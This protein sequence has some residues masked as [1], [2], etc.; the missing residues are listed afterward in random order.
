MLI[1]S[2][3]FN[4]IEGNCRRATPL[5]LALCSDMTRTMCKISKL[6]QCWCNQMCWGKVSTTSCTSRSPYGSNQIIST[7][8]D[9]KTNSSKIWEQLPY[10]AS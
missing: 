7:H 6:K 8:I 3:Q 1:K 9:T 4:S 10:R 5:H 2:Q